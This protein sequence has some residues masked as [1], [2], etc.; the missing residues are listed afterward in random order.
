MI[1]RVMIMKKY[2]E[3]IISFFK[4]SGICMMFIFCI[5]CPQITGK[6]VAEAIQRCL[7]DVIPSLCAM[8]MISAVMVRSGILSYTPRIAGRISSA[9]FGMEGHVMTIFTFSMFAGYPVGTSMLLERYEKKALSK[10]R[11][12]LLAGLCFGAGPAFIFGC[13]SGRYYSSSTAGVIMTISAVSANFLLAAAVSPMIRKGRSDADIGGRRLS[14]TSDT[15]TGC[16]ISGGKSMS[17]ICSTILFF[18]TVSA[19]LEAAGI[20]V[21]AGGLL[22]VISGLSEE[23]SADLLHGFVDITGTGRLPCDDYTLLPYLS[24]LAS[25][26]GLC[27]MLQL[28]AIV[29][30]RLS[31]KPILLMRTAAAILSG[32]ICRTITPFFLRRELIAVSMIK[33]RA[34]STHSPVPS[35]MLLIMTFMLFA[36]YGREKKAESSI[37]QK[38]VS[39]VS[40]SH[41]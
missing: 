22:S 38:S 36:C 8:M 30:G 14:L 4:G 37:I 3:M 6:A 32:V 34:F 17:V 9:L 26:G 16:V 15:L 24:A 21:K 28:N 25:F 2:T 20:Y 40:P 35:V 10:E 1:N 23:T 12:S 18:S 11:A 7:T 39:P 13:L 27:V 31:M 5:L 19:F 33:G 29:K 41:E